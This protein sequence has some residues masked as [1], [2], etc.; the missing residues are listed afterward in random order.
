MPQTNGRPEAQVAE[1]V[2]LT[3]GWLDGAGK[4][5]D[6]AG[7]WRLAGQ[8]RAH[9]PADAPYAYVYPTPDGNVQ[10]EWTFGRIEADLLVDLASGAGE[11][12]ATDTG[13]LRSESE[14]LDLERPDHWRR[15]SERLARLRLRGEAP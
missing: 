7:L 13:A 14:R 1:L 3:D 10:V 9:Y 8:F 15:L 11:F 6:P 5:P 12:T 2:Q 4:A